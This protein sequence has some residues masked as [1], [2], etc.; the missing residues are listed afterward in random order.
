MVNTADARQNHA[1]VVEGAHADFTN[2]RKV[3]HYTPRFCAGAIAE[4]YAPH[5]ALR[6]FFCANR[7]AANEWTRHLFAAISGMKKARES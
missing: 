1:L 4:L 7:K 2:P 6:I 3:H 5:S